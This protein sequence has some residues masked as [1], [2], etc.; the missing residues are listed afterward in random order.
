MGSRRAKE[1][2]WEVFHEDFYNRF[3]FA[4]IIEEKKIE[5]MAMEQKDMTVVENHARFLAL[6]WFV[7]GTF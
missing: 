1:R 7:P 4:T 2:V 5:L 6:A 3:L